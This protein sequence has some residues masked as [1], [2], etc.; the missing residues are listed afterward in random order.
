MLLMFG[1][2]T[3]LA[4]GVPSADAGVTI[5]VWSPGVVVFDPY[6][7]T[8]V[9]APRADY[10][11]IPGG[12]DEYG[13]FQPGYWQPVVENPGYSW[14]AGYWVGRAY[15]EGYWRP[16]AQP[17]RAWVDGYYLNNR[18]VRPRWVSSAAVPAV[19][20]HHVTR[21]KAVQRHKAGRRPKH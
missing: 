21:A 18:Y 20:R 6:T 5:S 9:P 7:P 12:Y 17:G 15:H 16:M 4:L 8:Y 11:W 2:A 1:L 10:V 14:A 13:N 19:Q 3:F